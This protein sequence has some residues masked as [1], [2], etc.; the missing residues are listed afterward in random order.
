MRWHRAVFDL[1]TGFAGCCVMIAAVILSGQ[2]QDARVFVVATGL[3][4]LAA[5]YLRGRMRG[6]N[7]I[8]SVLTVAAGGIVPVVAMHF[9]GV[10][11]DLTSY[12]IVFA[13]A[14]VSWCALGVFTRRLTGSG[15]GAAALGLVAVS[16]AMLAVVALAAL[17]A[18]VDASSLQS[19]DRAVPAFSL[20]TLDGRPMRSVD[21]FGG[22]VV[23]LA[24][25]ATWCAPCLAELPE[26]DRLHAEFRNDPRVMVVAVNT[27]SGG[28]TA[29]R[30]AGFLA[31][32]HFSFPAAID[33]MRPGDRG[34]AARSL[35]V[36]GIP[37]IYVLDRHGRLRIVHHGYDSSERLAA[38]LAA[39]VK[40]LVEAR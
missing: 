16:C 31:N 12:V 11:F 34:S 19:E 3:P 28:D 5:G 8:A 17:P 21:D 32:R 35:A 30:A 15:K 2:Q 26:I 24:F 25:W 4:Y 23:V 20:A 33:V 27:A 38:N 7:P 14:S 36:A 18:Y 29:E 39:S 22:R 10:A 6:H 13:V 9:T 1:V 37:A 40:K